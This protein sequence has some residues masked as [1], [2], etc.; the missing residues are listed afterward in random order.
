[1]NG[2]KTFFKSFSDR[3]VFWIVCV[4]SASDFTFTFGIIRALF[5][6]KGVPFVPMQSYCIFIETKSFNNLSNFL[7]QKCRISTSDIE[8]II[9]LPMRIDPSGDVVSP[10]WNVF[11]SFHLS[12]LSP[13]SI[14][15]NPFFI[16]SGSIIPITFKNRYDQRPC[17]LIRIIAFVSSRRNGIDLE[18]TFITI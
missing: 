17:W 15:K 5:I 11:P 12:L 1:L 16:N 4:E 3:K 6:S 2:F 18:L 8:D 14:W 13:S 10:F 9:I 7:S